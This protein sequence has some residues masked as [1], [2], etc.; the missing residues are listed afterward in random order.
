[1]IELIIIVIIV[2]CV[3]IM[4]KGKS[5]QA[6]SKPPRARSESLRSLDKFQ[7]KA[8]APKKTK[9]TWNPQVRVREYYKDSTVADVEEKTLTL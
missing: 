9:L 5:S 7:S 4:M 3:A 1:M 8:K 2:I 6:L